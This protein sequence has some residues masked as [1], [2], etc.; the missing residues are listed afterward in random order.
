MLN[1]FIGYTI[2][3][4]AVATLALVAYPGLFDWTVVPTWVQWTL[5]VSLSTVAALGVS[6]A[7]AE[8][9]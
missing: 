8:R 2:A 3:A 5:L 9:S 4:L 6:V 1:R 7:M